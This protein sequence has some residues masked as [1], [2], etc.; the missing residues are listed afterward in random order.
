MPRPVGAFLHAPGGGVTVYAVLP[1]GRLRWKVQTAAPVAS[2]PAIAAD[3]TV[4]V[5]SDDGSV[6]SI[7]AGGDVRWTYKTGGTVFSSPAVGSDGTV[8]VGSADGR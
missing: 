1:D 3:G 4:Y 7:G 5:G 8:Y 2:S 6:W